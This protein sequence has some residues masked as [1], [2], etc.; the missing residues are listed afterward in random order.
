MNAMFWAEIAVA[1]GST[2]LGLFIGYHAYRGFRRNDSR[3]MQ[4]LS[5]GLLLLTAVT[6]TISFG[7]TLLMFFE[8]LPDAYR[9]PTLLFARIT[10]LLGLVCIAYSLYRRPSV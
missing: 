5:I 1:S 2:G 8:V 4:F 10:Q 9:R 6:Y 3:S 7:S